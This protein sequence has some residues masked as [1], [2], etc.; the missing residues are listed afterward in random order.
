MKL[1]KMIV[2]LSVAT[3]FITTFPV[4][5]NVVQ[6]EIHPQNTHSISDATQT[7]D[8][9]A[10][11]NQ[12]NQRK[13]DLSAYTNE[14]P[15]LF[16]E[17]NN[18]N[19]VHNPHNLI[20]FEIIDFWSSTVN[21][22]MKL[23]LSKRITCIYVGWDDFKTQ[24]GRIN[25]DHVIISPE[26]KIMRELH[27]QLS[28][29]MVITALQVNYRGTLAVGDPFCKCGALKFRDLFGIDFT[30]ETNYGL[31]Y[32]HCFL[33]LTDGVITDIVPENA[34]KEELY[35]RLSLAYNAVNEI[36]LEQKLKKDLQAAQKNY[37]CIKD[38]R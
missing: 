25:D 18:I 24:T 27:S 3:F 12:I 22:V 23:L 21:K 11:L 32:K 30:P 10:L 17:I 28:S 34:T 2:T 9:Q 31:K 35:K 20:T 36:P 6:Y 38:L 8:T 13:A 7:A 33:I 19:F 5:D 16:K 26:I 1:G 4:S 15:P 14:L 29:H 37:Q